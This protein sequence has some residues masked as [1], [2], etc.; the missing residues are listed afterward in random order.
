MIHDS[1]LV[2][3][4]PAAAAN[5]RSFVFRVYDGLTKT[6][7]TVGGG[8]EINLVAVNA[9][10]SAWE[11]LASV[12]NALYTHPNHT[13]D[14]TSVA[15]GATTV[16]AT[17]L[18]GPSEDDVPR[19]DSTGDLVAG[20]IVDDGAGKVG[21]GETT[22][23]TG[24][25][26]TDTPPVLRFESTNESCDVGFESDNANSKFVVTYAGAGANALVITDGGDVV[27]APGS[28]AT[29]TGYINRVSLTL[30]SDEITLPTHTLPGIWDV[31]IDTESAAATDNCQDINGVATGD[32]I[33]VKITDGA[34]VVVF[35]HATGGGN[36][37]H[38]NFGSSDVTLSYLPARV[39]YQAR[40]E[41]ALDL[42]LS[43]S[44]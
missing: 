43:V 15:D 2:A 41:T 27:L 20:S 11:V 24:L 40:S 4:L 10:G 5:L 17:S 22:P 12:G 39:V 3:D 21:I 37:K 36:L 13:G 35:K 23:L 7:A 6:D 14:V 1:P 9:A 32:I 28:S 16:V 42:I 30:A 25:H 44:Q 34:R 29:A 31:T 19:I 38:Q 8:S 33:S 26:F 18:T